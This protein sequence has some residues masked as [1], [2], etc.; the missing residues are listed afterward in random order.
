VAVLGFDHVQLSIPVGRLGEALPFYVDI[1]GFERIP[2][3]PELDSRGAW[4]QQGPVQLHLGEESE[5]VIDGRAHPALRVDDIEAVLRRAAGACY[6]IRR[7][8][9]PKGFSHASVFDVFG[10]RIELMQ[11]ITS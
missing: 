10:N 7:D 2:K 1:L 3:P 6:R 11:E 8:E 9:G 4:L 5:F